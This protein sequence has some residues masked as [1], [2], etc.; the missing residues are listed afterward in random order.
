MS[1][2]P[3]SKRSRHTL[4]QGE[5]AGAGAGSSIVSTT[6]VQ[7]PALPARPSR[8][9]NKFQDRRNLLDWF[10]EPYLE[11]NKMAAFA[12]LPEPVRHVIA[13][14]EA[15]E[16]TLATNYGEVC[17]RNWNFEIQPG[18]VATPTPSAVTSVAADS[19]GAG[20]GAAAAAA[21]A[22]AGSSQV[23]RRLD[24][25][26]FCLDD[27]KAMSRWLQHILEQPTSATFVREDGKQHELQ[28][29]FGSVAIDFIGP[30]ARLV[31]T[32]TFEI[33]GDSIDMRFWQPPG[34]ASSVP[35]PPF[36]IRPENA[37]YQEL[38]WVVLP[39]PELK[40]IPAMFLLDQEERVSNIFQLLA[41][42]MSKFD[43]R[44]RVDITCEGDFWD[45][46]DPPNG[47]ILQFHPEPYFAGVSRWSEAIRSEDA[48]DY[49]TLVVESSPLLSSLG[50]NVSDKPW[51]DFVHALLEYHRQVGDED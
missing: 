16:C 30:E 12:K 32:I 15:D 42:M 14:Y 17:E 23:P 31:G 43:I 49:V 8:Q 1:D 19:A 29:S 50:R 13:T 21:E 22:G 44:V 11:E 9:R 46:Q 5:N 51:D 48:T 39:K 40:G 33:H 3:L 18:H 20:A 38:D 35:M 25:S 7:S 41:N 36:P 37:G 2:E 10:G 28:F 27:S 24:C 4:F 6:Q 34:D 47:R 26:R 45:D